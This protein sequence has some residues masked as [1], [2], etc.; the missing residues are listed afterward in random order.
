MKRL[1]SLFTVQIV[2]FSLCACGGKSLDQIEKMMI[3][4]KFLYN[5]PLHTY[6]E[7]SGFEY[8]SGNSGLLEFYDD[9]T[10]DWG[11]IDKRRLYKDN[12]I[13]NDS[14]FDSIDNRDIIDKMSGTF[15]L[16][17]TDEKI[18]VVL[19]V[20]TKNDAECD[21]FEEFSMCIENNMIKSIG[22][23]KSLNYAEQALKNAA[24]D[25]LDEF[26]NKW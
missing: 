17:K 10:F 12:E 20:T 5:N 11:T 22:G 26:N 21:E 2:L 4:D 18:V 14:Y 19:H 7:Y 8:K 9:G 25:A 3:G 13:Y 23:Y 16:N 24:K 15:E 1:I 6:Y